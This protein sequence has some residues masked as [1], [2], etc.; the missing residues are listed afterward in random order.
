VHFVALTA[1]SLW[2]FRGSGWR[3]ANVPRIRRRR[4]SSTVGMTIGGFI[5]FTSRV[6]PSDRRFARSRAGTVFVSFLNAISQTAAE[7]IR[8]R[9]RRWR[10][11]RG[12]DGPGAGVQPCANWWLNCYG[13]FYRSAL[14]AVFDS[15]DLYLVRW[16]R[17][18][19]SA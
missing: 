18:N 19:T 9:V 13:R 3:S 17:R 5:S 15:L 2:Q 6:S 4:K 10:P 8:Q 14:Y 12:L 1:G 11:H 7:G 16:V